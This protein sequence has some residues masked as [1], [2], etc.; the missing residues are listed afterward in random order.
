MKA[1]L[2][3]FPVEM[4]VLAGSDNRSGLGVLV[5]G[6]HTGIDGVETTSVIAVGSDSH[7]GCV[8]TTRLNPCFSGNSTS[9]FTPTSRV[10]G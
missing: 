1:F 10:S 3:R 5:K 2:F 6:V 8:H 7:T 9:D 4:G